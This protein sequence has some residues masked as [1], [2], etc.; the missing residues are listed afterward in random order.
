MKRRVGEMRYP[1]GAW[2]GRAVLCA[3]LIGCGGQPTAPIDVVDPGPPPPVGPVAPLPAS[4]RAA[5][6]AGG[7]LAVAGGVAAVAE[8][9]DDRVFV[10]DLASQRARGVA[11]QAGDE[12]G[13]VIADSEGRFFVALRRGGAVVTID[14]QAAQIS[15]R[16]AV[17]ATPRGLALQGSG[18]GARLHVACQSGEL[19]TLG[20]TGAVLRTLR[21]PDGDNLG[22]LRDVLVINDQLYVT[23]FRGAELL[24][25]DADGTITAT[26]RPLPIQDISMGPMGPLSTTKEAGVAW[27][28]LALPDGGAL[29]LHQSAQRE[30][31]TPGKG[32]YSGGGSCPGG[33]V[34]SAATRFAPGLSSEPTSTALGLTVLPLD[35]A[36]NREGTRLAILAAGNTVGGKLGPL[37]LFDIRQLSQGRCLLG[38]Q[39]PRTSNAVALAYDAAG[40]L[41]VQTRAPSALQLVDG[42]T[43]DALRTISLASGGADRGHDLFHQGTTAFLACA[44]CHPEGG[45][46]GRVWTFVGIGPRRTQSLRGGIMQTAPFH[47]DGDL[48]T[49]DALMSEVFLKR[50][51]GPLLGAT[52]PA[53]AAA[54]AT[55]IDAQ[56]ALPRPSGGDAAAVARGQQLFSDAA[57]GCAGCHSGARFT[58]NGSAD[59]GTGKAFQVP[60]LLGLSAHAPYL[61]DGSAASLRARFADRSDRHGTTSQLSPGQIDDMVAYLMTL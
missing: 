11:L 37:L 39:A 52:S 32:G 28:T 60:Q 5:A 10:V 56:P 9:G 27:R 21:L 54:L 17:C 59:V 20:A 1:I 15:E 14:G 13:R 35:L 42:L 34:S 50:M 7:T 19:V 49:M 12:P 33:I 25:V 23:R 43:G 41:W 53:D 55:W 40:G 38:N 22:D 36:L 47:W 8:P 2:L 48:A 26:Q 31:V 46:D 58:S 24:R 18:S 3:A 51:G 45:E 29:M 6:L 44:S 4:Q 57:I 30:P 61:H 16:R